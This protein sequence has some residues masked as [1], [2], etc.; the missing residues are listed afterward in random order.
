LVL[1]SQA[2]PKDKVVVDF[3]CNKVRFDR[4]TAL[5]RLIYENTRSQGFHTSGAKVFT[6]VVQSHSGRD[7]GPNQQDVTS[8]R[9]EFAGKNDLALSVPGHIHKA[10]VELDVE[11]AYQIGQK[12]KSIVQ[13]PNDGKLT[14]GRSSANVLG[15]LDYPILYL[16]F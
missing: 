14:R 15:K 13:Y 4:Q 3:K 6:D 7:N 9:I 5:P 12:Y 10:T 1:N 2:V 11:R 8:P 16:F